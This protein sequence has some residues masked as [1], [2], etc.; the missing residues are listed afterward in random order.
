M[1][2]PVLDRCAALALA[3]VR[4]EY[5]NHLMLLA[6]CDADLRPPRELTPAFFG[7]FDWHSSVHA[8]WSLVRL[9]RRQPGAAWEAEA[10][11]VLAGH[12][13]EERLEGE[14]AFMAAPERAGWER[15]YGLAW[16][17]QLCAEL[18]GWREDRDAAAWR[19]R[20][21]PL[22]A[23]AA[24][25]IAAWLPRLRY[26]NRSGEHAQLA[27]SMGLV[28]DWARTVGNTELERLAAERSLAF[29]HRDHH[30]PIDYEPSGHDFLSPALG[31]AD[32]LRRLLPMEAYVEWFDR[33][34]PDLDSSR[35]ARWL[36]PVGVT[37]PSDGKLAHLDGLNLTRAW[38]LEGVLTALPAGHAARATLEQAARAHTDAGLA[39][40][41]G[42]HYAGTHWLGSFAVYLVTRRGIGG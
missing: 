42:D 31:E 23:V 3:N 14:R 10:R 4:R 25:S 17:L 22:E 12:L 27:F 33:F 32:L 36:T 5:P 35:A 15:P 34:L 24:R 28:L 40:I 11:E 2:T 26:P 16:L 13:T 6:T 29:Y 39:S 9:L 18:A 37:D 38:M 19:G 1:T 30:A 21:A 8:H 7:S 20:I 41:A